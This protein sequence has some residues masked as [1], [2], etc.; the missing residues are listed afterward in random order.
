MSTQKFTRRRVL[1]GAAG[2]TA[3]IVVRGSAA[4]PKRHRFVVV[5]RGPMGAAAARHLATAGEDVVVVGPEEPKDWSQHEGAFASHYDEGRQFELASSEKVLDRSSIATCAATILAG[6]AGTL[7]VI[8]SHY[9]VLAALGVA[10]AAIASAIAQ[11]ESVNQHR[12][13]AERYA[14]TCTRLQDVSKMLSTTR[15]AIVNGDRD[16]L[17]KFFDV[18]YEVLLEEHAQWL[19]LSER[20]SAAIANL[21]ETLKKYSQDEPPAAV[22]DVKNDDAE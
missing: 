3:S 15:T 6:W 20:K 13:N 16:A 7:I 21:E 2:L 10:A 12:R 22:L 5:G 14:D 9:S 4:A 11:Q 17:A 18:V 1:A 19:E 8:D